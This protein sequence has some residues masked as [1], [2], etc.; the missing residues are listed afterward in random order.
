MFCG[1]V[2]FAHLSS[3]QDSKYRIILKTR[4]FLSLMFQISFKL[5]ILFSRGA[6]VCWNELM[7]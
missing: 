2:V 3:P 4:V 6:M 5:Q 7:S 1:H